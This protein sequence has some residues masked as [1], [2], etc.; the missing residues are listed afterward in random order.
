MDG[1]MN[2]H[3]DECKAERIDI[4]DKKSAGKMYVWMDELP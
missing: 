1:Q 3:T 4:R 2:E